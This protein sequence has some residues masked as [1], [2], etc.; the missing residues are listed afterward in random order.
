MSRAAR[1]VSQWVHDAVRAGVCVS[2]INCQALGRATL[3]SCSQYSDTLCQGA[4]CSGASPCANLADRNFFCDFSA[5]GGQA[6]SR[7]SQGV[8]GLCPDGYSSDGM[9]CYECPRLST[10]SRMGDVQ[11]YGEAAPGEEPGCF[12]AYEGSVGLCPVST[13]PTRVVT[14]GP[15]IRPNGNCAPYFQC[16]AGYFKHF[17]A[18]GQVYCEPCVPP[19]S[20]GALPSYFTWFSGG[21]SVNDP[22]SCLYECQGKGVWPGG[23]CLS[24]GYVLYTPSNAPGFYDD[25]TGGGYKSCPVGFTSVKNQAASAGD[26][27]P[28]PVQTAYF[29]DACGDWTCNNRLTKRGDTC[30]D[31]QTCPQNSVGYSIGAKGGCLPYPLPWQSP[32]YQKAGYQLPGLN[33]GLQIFM[34]VPVPNLADSVVLVAQGASGETLT[35][36]SLA[37]GASQRHW[38]MAGPARQVS[39]PGQVC[40]ASSSVLAGHEYVFLAFCNATFLSFLDLSLASPSPRLLIG[41]TTAGYVEGFRDQALFQTELYVASDSTSSR[42]FVSD[43]FNCALRVVFIPTSPGDFLTRTYWLYGS[44]YGTCMT[45][46]E[47]LL[48]PGRLYPVTVASQMFYLFP[49]DDGLYQLDGG[50][51]SVLQIVPKQVLP[52]WLP[53]LFALTG[54]DMP[55]ASTIRLQFRNLTALVMPVQQLCSPGFTSNLGGSCSIACSTDVN[56]VD[57]TTGACLPCATQACGAGY[58]NIP[59]TPNSPQMCV[60]CPVLLPLQGLYPRVYSTPGKCG[61]DNTAFVDYCPPNWFLTSAQA[62]GGHLRCAPCPAF[63]STDADGATSVDQCRCFPGVTR[64][65]SGTCVVGQ[66]YPLPLI[67]KCPFGTYHRGVYEGCTSCRVDPF[68]DCPVGAYPTF[69]GSCLPCVRPYNSVFTSNGNGVNDPSTCAFQCLPGFYSSSNSTFMVST[70]ILCGY[71][72]T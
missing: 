61:I 23:G 4:S 9:F 48:H 52:V 66:L 70:L 59:C 40:S 58:L 21:L 37:Y 36:Y 17:Y 3:A 38:M 6:A 5:L 26:C 42:L 7:N 19:G 2:C 31:L 51:R 24:T 68:P 72:M 29:G 63:S 30:I 11:C 49:A 16:A 25:G 43:R 44:T 67:S 33:T 18:T 10:C 28:C 12:G 35:F 65:A 22:G 71:R 1:P 20:S 46:T 8:C 32:G 54:I 45:D 13:D 14:R 41:S 55:N 15:F 53:S 34:G 69:N 39:L 60:L 27:V 56:Y 64:V 62:P 57:P 50:T 47:A